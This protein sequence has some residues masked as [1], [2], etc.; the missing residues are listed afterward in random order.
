MP[1]KIWIKS[2]KLK[3]ANNSGQAHFL[4]L[5][6]RSNDGKLKNDIKS[7][8]TSMGGLDPLLSA[9]FDFPEIQNQMDP[10]IIPRTDHQKYHQGNLQIM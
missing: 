7:H 8:L 9:S 3:K 1:E 5:L 10:Q 2:L 4:S 6:R